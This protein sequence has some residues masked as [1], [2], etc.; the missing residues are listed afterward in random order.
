[1][2]D[3]LALQVNGESLVAWIGQTVVDRIDQSDLPIDFPPQQ[4]TGVTGQSPAIEIRHDLPASD[5]CKSD[6]C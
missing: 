3:H 2:R 5:R 4:H 6:G 1:L